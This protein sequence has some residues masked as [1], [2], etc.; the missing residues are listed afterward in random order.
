MSPT[1]SVRP[2][3]PAPPS[4]SSLM[5]ALLMKTRGRLLRTGGR[6]ARARRAESLRN[7]GA[8][9]RRGVARL[10]LH[11]R[12]LE[13]GARTCSGECRRDGRAGAAHERVRRA[14]RA[15]L[16]ERFGD[17]GKERQRGRLEVVLEE[18]TRGGQ[19]RTVC[20]RLLEQHAVALEL[21]RRAGE[22]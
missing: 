19:R 6:T 14:G 13:G 18:R 10:Q 1:Y 2:I 3:T 4:T 5:F 21:G 15:R 22:R 20:Q 12:T 9:N 16:R 11:G 8:G 7:G 17:R